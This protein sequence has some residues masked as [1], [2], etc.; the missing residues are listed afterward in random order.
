MQEGGRKAV[1]A[2]FIWLYVNVFVREKKERGGER[3]SVCF[4]VIYGITLDT[5][6]QL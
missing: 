3:E 5:F 6:P 4:L 1:L 2:V